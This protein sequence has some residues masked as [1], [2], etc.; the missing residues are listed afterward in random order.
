MRLIKATHLGMCFGVRDAVALAFAESRQPLTILGDLVHNETVAAALR[1][2]GIH[3]VTDPG[4]VRTPTVMITAHG[5]SSRT[6]D[7][8]RLQGLKVI[9]ATC[10]LVHL[11]H[12]AV[13]RLVREGCHPVIVGKRDHVE[14]RGITDDLEAFDV[15][16]TEADVMA[17][18]EHARYGVAAQTTQ[19]IERVRHLV[20]C[21]RRR[22]PRSD[23]T[24]IDTVC[25]PTK[26]RQHAAVEVA[27]QSDVVIVIGGAH[28]NNSRELVATCQ[29]HCRRV[30]FVQ[31]E[32]DL[33]REWLEGANTVGL[34]AGTSTP[35]EIINAVECR[36][37][38]W[39]TVRPPNPP[40]EHRNDVKRVSVAH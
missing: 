19:P 18:P 2:R 16:L 28:S 3:T 24:F 11:A 40:T 30:Q 12:R 31:T 37:R 34:T 15:I 26:Q 14:V 27:Q 21:L 33:R 38:E 20:A 8:V 4:Q 22:F 39:L 17:L 1:D 13:A 32:N 29:Q 5:T 7:R 10:P 9:E 25:Q 23:V 36:L 6:L 35:D